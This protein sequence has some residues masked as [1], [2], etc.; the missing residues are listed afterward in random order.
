[1]SVNY[2]IRYKNKVCSKVEHTYAIE[3]KF[4]IVYL[5]LMI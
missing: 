5:N 3:L 1:M 2:K 4:A